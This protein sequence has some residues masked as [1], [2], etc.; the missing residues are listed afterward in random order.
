MVAML[1]L[2]VS[3]IVPA[4]PLATSVMT[5]DGTVKSSYVS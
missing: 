5:V 2:E 3:E 4:G 1:V